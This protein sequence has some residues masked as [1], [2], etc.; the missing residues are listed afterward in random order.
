MITRWTGI[1]LAPQESPLKAWLTDEKG[2]GYDE[3]D[4]A[5]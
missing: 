2:H 4:D 3:E 5:P 1:E